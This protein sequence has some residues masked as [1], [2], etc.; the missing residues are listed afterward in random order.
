[1]RLFGTRDSRCEVSP[2][3]STTIGGN[4]PRMVDNVGVFS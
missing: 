2:G 4:L 3:Q 1:M